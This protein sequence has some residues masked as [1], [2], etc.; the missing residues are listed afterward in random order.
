MIIRPIMS[1]TVAPICNGIISDYDGV[2]SYAVLDENLS[3]IRDLLGN[4]IQ[5]EY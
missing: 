2:S 1:S 4:I 5:E 3:A